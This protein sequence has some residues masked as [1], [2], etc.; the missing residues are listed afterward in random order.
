MRVRIPLLAGCAL[1]LAGC[2][3][4]DLEPAVPE[5]RM[6]GLDDA[7]GVVVSRVQFVAQPDEWPEGGGVPDHVTPILVDLINGS[8]S[9]LRIEYRLFSLQA[10]TG[11]ALTA[12]PPFNVYGSA[13]QPRVQRDGGAIELSYAAE[14]F[15]VAPFYADLYSELSP[16]R[17][18]FVADQRFYGAGYA[19]WKQTG[20]A[21]PT[22]TMRLMALPEGVLQPGGRIGGYLYF[23]KV[24]S[25][26][27][28]VQLDFSLV[29][30][31]T[32]RLFAIASLPFVV[33]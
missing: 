2:A 7:A 28:R 14:R 29:D 30:A 18:P 31:K 26:A 17:G 13:T 11:Q 24:P 19:H 33:R 9:P 27:A 4:S 21:L 16:Y 12:L 8:R 3:G 6:D 10:G 15:E 1:W 5:S 23:Q 32:G 25:D 22:R 20:G